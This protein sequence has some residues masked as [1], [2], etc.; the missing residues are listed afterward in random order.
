MEVSPYTIYRKEPTSM[1]DN[2]AA[3]SNNEHHTKTYRSLEDFY[4]DMR[5][6]P[7]YPSTVVIEDFRNADWYQEVGELWVQTFTRA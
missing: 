6:D 4:E 5:Y 2:P 7:D 1:S 3:A